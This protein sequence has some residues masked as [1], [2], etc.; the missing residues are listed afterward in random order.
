MMMMMMMTRMSGYG[1]NE[2]RHGNIGIILRWMGGVMTT[3]CSGCS[4]GG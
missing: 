1:M 2:Q 4:G 3:R